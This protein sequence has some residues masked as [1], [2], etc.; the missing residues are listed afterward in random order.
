[1]PID[2]GDIDL[3]AGFVPK[4]SAEE[5]SGEGWHYRCFLQGALTAGAAISVS[6]TAITICQWESGTVHGKLEFR[7]VPGVDLKDELTFQ[8]PGSTYAAGNGSS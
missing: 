5:S 2:F 8:Q 3:S 7:V 4:A 1:M 6:S